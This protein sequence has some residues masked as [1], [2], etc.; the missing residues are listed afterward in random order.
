M[1]LKP[2]LKSLSESCGASG[3]EDEVRDVIRRAFEPLCDE[4]RTDAMGNLIALKRGAQQ[5]VRNRKRIL[6]AGHM[7]E[8][9]LMV[10]EIEKGFIRFTQV[11]G[12]DVRVLPA[13]PVVVHGRKRLAGLVA[14]V[15]PHVSGRGKKSTPM[16][17]LYIDVGLSEKEL[18][19]QVRIGDVITFDQ[20]CMELTDE[21]LCGKAF[22]DRASIAAIVEC[23]DLLNRTSH[24]WD[25][26]AVATV[27]EEIG[28]RGATTSTFGVAPDLGIAIDVGFG[29]QPGVP[30][31]RAIELGKGP[32]IS[33]G[34]NIHPRLFEGLKK[35]ATTLEIP[36]QIE[37]TSRGTGTD[38]NAI[39]LTREGIPTA[40]LSIPER[41]MHTPVETIA[42]KDVERTGRLMAHYIAALERSAL[43]AFTWDDDNGGEA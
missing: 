13:Q 31:K 16:E 23:L 4:I 30:E 18:N 11:G 33:M 28:I 36:Y 21:L 14:S 15:P 25:V 6:L 43:D 34:P 1:D 8:I 37:V 24:E 7:D 5:G 27:Q 17:E 40:L 19:K 42:V 29:K 41:N 2:L 39:Q 3:H 9:G 12:H 10:T 22:D 32:G 35:I 20:R 38:A 26:Y